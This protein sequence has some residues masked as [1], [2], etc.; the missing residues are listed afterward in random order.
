[1]SIFV[2]LIFVG[3]PKFHADNIDSN[4]ALVDAVTPI[5]LSKGCTLGQLSLAWL[6]AQGSD[7][8]PIPGTIHCTA[9]CTELHYIVLNCLFM[10]A[11]HCKG[12]IIW[13]DIMN[14]ILMQWYCHTLL[15]YVTSISKILN[16]CHTFPHFL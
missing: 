8:I 1:M 13:Y 2:C 14:F 11:F 6:H 4:L 10:I 15:L 12:Y 5:A 9:V 3:S 7:V 16:S